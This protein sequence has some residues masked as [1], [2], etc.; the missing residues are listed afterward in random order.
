[1]AR[2][3][4]QR[5]AVLISAALA[6]PAAAHADPAASEGWQGV[7]GAG[8]I[9][10]PR[11]TGGRAAQAW[12]I[13]LVSASWNDAIYIEPL[14]AGAYFWGSADR[15]MGLGV[16]VEPRMGFKASDAPR[17]TGLTT[18][19][20]SLEG[21]PAFDWDWG[22]V[23]VSAS[24]FTDLTGSSRGGSGRLYL[25]WPMVRNGTWD[26]TA[27]AGA[28][29][30]GNRVANYFFGVADAE[31]TADRPAFRAR[32]STDA[33][34]GI[35]GTRLLGQDYALIFGLQDTRLSGGVAHSPIVETRHS[36]VGWIGLALRL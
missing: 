22:P 9:V 30:L 18:R 11:Y 16:A 13:P 12:L 32:A 20:D 14:R 3:R 1:M 10:F 26:V 35:G 33:L 21:G 2:C 19:H 24:L 8:P 34:A 31:A 7:A 27:F 15:S 36:S 17:L 4:A 29:R 5:Y 28:E 6:L 23:A 25:V